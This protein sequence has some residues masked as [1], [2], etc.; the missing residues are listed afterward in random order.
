MRRTIGKKMGRA[1]IFL[2]S[3]NLIAAFAVTSFSHDAEARRHRRRRAK[4][5][6]IINEKKLYERI[7]GSKGV[8][9]IVDEWMRLNLGDQRTAP[10]FSDSGAGLPKP[11]K[12][13]KVRKSLNDQIC[14]LSDG[15]CLRHLVETKK[16][17]DRSIA[18][19]TYLVFADNLFRSMQKYGVPE[20]EK[21]EMLGRLGDLRLDFVQPTGA[22]IKK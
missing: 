8:S 20:R 6:P 10:L 5:A 4:H 3:L 2:M 21:N 14:E 13:S 1:F 19:D 7:G 22:K 17:A 11:E 16:P 9:E 12:I 15:P 18:D